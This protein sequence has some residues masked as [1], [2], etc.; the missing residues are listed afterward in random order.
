MKALKVMWYGFKSAN[1]IAAMLVQA[2]VQARRGVRK[3][4]V[5]WLA[6]ASNPLWPAPDRA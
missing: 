1:S 6:I 3:S 5:G 4:T 2:F